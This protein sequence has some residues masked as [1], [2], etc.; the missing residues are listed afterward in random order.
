M[1][2]L[3]WFGVGFLAGAWINHLNP[4]AFTILTPLGKVMFAVLWTC[5]GFVTLFFGVV[6]MVQDRPEKPWGLRFW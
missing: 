4:P 2:W 3:L 5:S 6:I 1:G